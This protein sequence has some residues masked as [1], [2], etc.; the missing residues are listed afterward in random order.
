MAEIVHP[1]EDE[2]REA[3]QK[4][5]TFSYQKPTDFKRKKVTMRL[6]QTDVVRASVQVIKEGG[7]NNLHYHS[8]VDGMF[9]VLNGR[10]RFYGPENRV[11]GEFGKFEGIIIPKNAR[12][13]FESIGTE[14]AEVMLV[15]GFH[16]KGAELSGRTD[17]EAPKLPDAGKGAER[18][19]AQQTRPLA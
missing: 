10:V 16:T 18:F 13:W 7:E 2:H 19:Q 15:Q 5:V 12:Y 17:V 6:A 14:E 9:T 1:T 4:I 8:T 11:L 3:E